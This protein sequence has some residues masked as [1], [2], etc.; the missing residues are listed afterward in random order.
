MIELLGIQ[1]YRIRERHA[2][3]DAIYI[4]YRNLH[5]TASR[6]RRAGGMRGRISPEHGRKGS[7]ECHDRRADDGAD[8][9][10][11]FTAYQLPTGALR[12][13]MPGARADGRAAIGLVGQRP[14]RSFTLTSRQINE[15]SLPDSSPFS[16]DLEMWHDMP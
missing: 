15:G 9:G 4:A 16:S 13:R 3:I 12:T 5:W 8:P 1:H 11:D 14:S 10:K 6:W 7:D 2:V